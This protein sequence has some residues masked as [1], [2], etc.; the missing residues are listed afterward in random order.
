MSLPTE[1]D[2]AIVKMGDGAG[3]EVFTAICGIQ[4]VN[5]NDTAAT[6][7]HFP[8][9]CAKPGE[10]PSRR[11]KTN[12]R[13]LDITG[14]GLSNTAQIAL[15]KAAVAKS[16]NYKIECY[17][18]DGTDAGSLLGTYSGAFV[19]TAN[20]ISVPRDAPASLDLSLASNGAWTYA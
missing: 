4:D 8:R 13:Q 19:L 1:I 18:D 6:S 14:K 15:V 5:I 9:D 3:S 17:A 10:V 7:D 2:F 16:K 12:S 20:N 11:V